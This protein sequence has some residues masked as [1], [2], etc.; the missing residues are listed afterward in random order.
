[1]T[2]A[3]APLNYLLCNREGI[4]D[5]ERLNIVCLEAGCLENLAC[6]CACIDS[7]HKG[8]RYT[9][10]QSDQSLSNLSLMRL[11]NSQHYLSTKRWIS[12][13]FL[14]SSPPKGKV[15]SM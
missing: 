11:A 3:K 6:C 10:K 4:H 5:E 13:F 14:I 9:L 7:D 12:M 1:M 2:L 15:H 8:H